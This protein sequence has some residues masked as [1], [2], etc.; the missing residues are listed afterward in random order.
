MNRPVVAIVAVAAIA[1]GVR[2][3]GLSHPPGLVFDEF[4]YAKSACILV[5]GSDRTCQIQED[6]ERSFRDSKWDVGSWVHPPLGKWMIALGEKAFGMRPFGWRISSAVAGTAT[7]VVVASIAQLLFGSVLW[8]FLAGLLLAIESLNVVM[9]RLALLDVFLEL[10]VALGFLFLVLDR[11]WI[12]DRSP[13]RHGG[14]PSPLWRP[15][16]F[17]AGLALGAAVSVKWSGAMAIVGA[18]TLAYAWETSR[19]RAD[20][21]VRLRAA[22][23]RAFTRET[24]GIAIAFVALPIAVYLI[25]YAPW[26]HHFGWSPSDWWE[27]QTAMFRYH[28]GLTATALDAATGTYTPTHPYYSEAWT[29]LPMLR[30][31]NLYS[32]SADGS[33]SQIVAIGNPVIFWGTIWT[34]PYAVVAWWRT[35]DWRAGFV[36]VA[37]LAQFLPWLVVS[38]P[39]FFFYIL[40][41]T[42]FMV[43]AAIYTLRDLHGATIVLRDPAS[44]T[45]V[46]STRHPYRPLV[47]G[48]VIG[49]VGLFV[50]FW[51]VLTAHDLSLTM[52]RARIWFRGWV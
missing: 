43:L 18:V 32:P 1:A 27:N 37:F 17:A 8:T 3:W 9:A 14:V 7:V 6:A 15:W 45:R 48:Y 30:P 38:R 52:W 16:R 4:Y 2:L 40:P 21:D 46:E 31:V 23:G 44:G 28:R 24:L 42:P 50:W 13:P 35:R 25:A 10:W 33:I 36:S 12:G 29:W 49:A 39:Q 22:F 5:G 34:I 11:R 51:P 19:R 26:F 20:D 47:W 41:A